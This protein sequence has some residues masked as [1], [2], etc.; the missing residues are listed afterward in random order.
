MPRPTTT[1]TTTA[2]PRRYYV[3]S[4][5]AFGAAASASRALT[6]LAMQNFA[7]PGQAGWHLGTLFPGGTSA[8]ETGEIFLGI[9]FRFCR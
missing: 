9:L 3:L 6:N 1:T 2:N 8:Q 7:A 4:A 5:T